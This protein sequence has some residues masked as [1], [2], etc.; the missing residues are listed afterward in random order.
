MSAACNRKVLIWCFTPQSVVRRQVATFA[1]MWIT[2]VAA[3]V[4]CYSLLQPVLRTLPSGHSLGKALVLGKGFTRT[5]QLR[6]VRCRHVSRH[7]LIWGT[8]RLP[9][10][11]DLQAAQHHIA[12]AW[13]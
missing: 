12:T 3:P 10:Y 8:F 7:I 13:M 6:H 4:L 2:N 5:C 1:S 11:I 9:P